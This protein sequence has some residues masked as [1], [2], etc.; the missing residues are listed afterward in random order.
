MEK[1]IEWLLE[2]ENPSVKYY[3]LINIVGEKLQ[4]SDVFYYEDLIRKSGSAE[5]F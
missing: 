3:T 2:D 5:P 1:S 4:P